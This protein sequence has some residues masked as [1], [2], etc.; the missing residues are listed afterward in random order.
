MPPVSVVAF[1]NFL[2]ETWVRTDV[3]LAWN[4]WQPAAGG[5]WAGIPP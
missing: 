1:C 5:G 4:R 2:D 3:G